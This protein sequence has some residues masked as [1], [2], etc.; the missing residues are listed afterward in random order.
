MEKVIWCI[1]AS[2]KVGVSDE[3]VQ[4]WEGI[5]QEE[6]AEIEKDVFVVFFFQEYRHR[7]KEKQKVNGF[8][9]P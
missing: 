9:N 3:D 4:E 8:I 2:E 7:Q 5:Y 1:I 6:E